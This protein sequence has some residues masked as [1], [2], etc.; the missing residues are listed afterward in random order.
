MRLSPISHRIYPKLYLSI[1]DLVVYPTGWCD[2]N[3]TKFDGEGSR[4]TSEYVSQYFA[5]LGEAGSIEALHI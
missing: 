1:F 5:Q 2:P 4:T 3:F